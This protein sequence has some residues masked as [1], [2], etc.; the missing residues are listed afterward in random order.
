MQQ[1][2][3]AAHQAPLRQPGAQHEHASD[4]AFADLNAMNFNS[5]AADNFDSEPDFAN[6]AHPQPTPHQVSLGDFSLV[7]I[8]RIAKEMEG[9]KQR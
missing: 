3:L 5:S 6:F 7:Q 2:Q 9:V 4:Q 8:Q 1:Q